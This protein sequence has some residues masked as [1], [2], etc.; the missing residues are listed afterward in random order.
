MTCED[1]FSPSACLVLDD[2]P[3]PVYRLVMMIFVVYVWIW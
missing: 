3:S 2:L 1:F